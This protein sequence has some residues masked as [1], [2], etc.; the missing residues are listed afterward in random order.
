MPWDAA[1]RLTPRTTMALPDGLYDLLLTEGL[2]RSLAAIDPT[3]ADV[4]AL[5]GGAAE[6]LA[7]VIT[8][9]L[10]TILDD[11][12]GDDAEKAK[13]QLELVNELLVMLRHRLHA[14]AGS[15]GASA[16]AEV[17]D[18]VASPLRVLRAVQ[19]D[20]QFPLSP[21][22]GLAVPWLFTAGKGSPSLLQEIRRELAS[23][24]QVDILVSF[25]TVSGVR[26]LQDVLQQITAM[27][28]QGRAA[29]RLR[30]LT[31]TYTGATEAR[32]L[33]ELARLPGCEVRVSLDGRRTRLHAKAWLFQRKSGFGSAY[34][35]SANLSGA[36]L[37]GG[38]EWT[39][40]LTQRAQEAL[41]ARAVAHFETLWADNE[42]QRY[43]PDNVEH[44]QALAAA[45]GRESFGGEPSATISFFDLQPKTYQQEMLEQLANERAHGRNRNLLVAA[46]GTG[47]TVVAAFDYRY[48]CRIE[49]GRP[50]LLFVAHREEILRQALRT[51]REVLR[52]PE[53]G[54]VLTGSH[55]PE[56]WDH[57]FATIDS[58]T[59]RDLV[60]TVGAD[61][62]H[63]VVVDECHRLAAD[64]FDAFVKAVRPRV[65]LGLTATPERSDGQP[66]AQYF[67]ARPDGSSAVELRLWHALDLQLLAP[68]EYYACDDATDFSAVPWDR[69]GEREAVDQLVTGNDVRARL[70]VNE[71]RRLASDASRSRAIVFCVSVAHAEFMTDWINRAGLPAACVVGATASEER[72]RA[73]Q[74]LLSGELCALVTVDLYNEGIDLPMVDTLLLL[75][76]TQSPVLFQQQIGRGLRLAPGKESCLVLDFVGQHR[77]EFRFDRL[78]SSLTGL[79]RR[80]LVDGVE[81]GFGSLPPGC[82]IHLQRQTREQVLQGLRALTTQNWRRLKTELQTYAALKGRT[83]VRLADFLH[84]QALELEDV[85]RIGT[86]QGRSGWTALKRDAGLIVAEPGPEE[87]Y[88]S[89]RFGDLLHVDD[90]R[91]LDVMAAIGALQGQHDALD[92]QGALG[93]QMLAYQIDGRHEQAAGHDA[94]AERLERH[95]AIASELVELSGLLQ[96]RSTLGAHAIPGLEDT[97]LCLHAAYGVREVLTAVGWL[98]AARRTPFQAGVLPLASRKTELLF[99][100]LDKSEG[101]HER[102]SYHDYAISAERFHWQ[103]QNS[104]G[105][106]TPSGRRYLESSTSGWQ[107]QLF[108]R[109]RKGEAYRACG[110]AALES[111]EGDRPLSIVW[112]LETPLPARL[113]REFSV[114]RRV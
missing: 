35:G 36:A 38:L 109:P 16:S 105:P 114:L 98:T 7:D 52:D 50:R 42:F 23:S 8:R 72:R 12:S 113:F 14:N 70:V 89:R 71:W 66:I 90:P 63:T 54:D 86:G 100:T 81:N 59:S 85:Y 75:R 65:L 102:I 39:V 47:K 49:G 60:A 26:K 57:L 64:R 20:Q 58:V 62:W 78:L 80:E 3:C 53:F 6:F 69:P 21:E 46:T 43:D 25:I 111:A 88:F 83:A 76:P 18:L 17:V 108:V 15:N 31:T 9:Q 68:F 84:D 40:K 10:A 33:D 96:A 112:K 28:G 95:P 11:V 5:K 29:T 103:T 4:L 94:F 55:Q 79:S 74:R 56:Q 99:V 67:D 1:D 13:R 93:M 110:R 101:Y 24:D 106:D 48:T 97:P 82:H 91:R 41:F 32:A 19:R 61:H 107:F 104:A 87:G 44:R 34:V 51:Y 92:A 37:T 73:P 45:L 27:G 22:I 77:T 2:A 30:I